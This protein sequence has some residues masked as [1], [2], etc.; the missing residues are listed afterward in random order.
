MTSER[1]Q[2]VLA[3]AGV[4]S[5][6]AS[7][8]LI[9]QGRVT[10]D[11]SPAKIGAKV[12]PAEVD[13]RVDGKRIR[14]AERTI[15]L[16]LNKPGKVLSST[17]SQ[18]GMPTVLDFVHVPERVYPVG[19]LDADSEGLI[20]LTNDGE[21]AH[22]LTHPRYEHEKEYLVLLNRRPDDAQL[23]TWRRG[24]VLSEGY[25]T[26]P[27]TVR[28]ESS[29]SPGRWIR[30]VLHEGRKRQ[31]RETAQVLGLNVNRIIRTRLHT[32]ELGSLGLGE[33]RQLTRDEVEALKTA[34]QRTE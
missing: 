19:R 3:K 11:G 15:Y 18:G 27:A 31:I 23:R 4:A 28:R 21:L 2:K 32:L 22:H 5:R 6:R 30:V 8:V 29:P 20:L 33:S 13:I 12:D 25:K 10:V 7:E 16:A 9:Q 26:R 1:L 17:K 34:I 24:V 14:A